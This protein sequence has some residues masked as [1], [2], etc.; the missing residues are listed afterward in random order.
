MQKMQPHC[1]NSN[2]LDLNCLNKISVHINT[3]KVITP[4]IYRM[5]A[6][7]ATSVRVYNSVE[8]KPRERHWRQ[9][10]RGRHVFA[11]QTK[12]EDKT[13]Q[14]KQLQEKIH[15]YEDDNKKLKLLASWNFRSTKSAL[16][17]ISELMQILEADENIKE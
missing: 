11:S 8:N 3:I 14:I 6:I 16:K 2:G 9:Y 7:T 5:F 15:K 12:I 17:D 1:V 4:I 10:S 13:L